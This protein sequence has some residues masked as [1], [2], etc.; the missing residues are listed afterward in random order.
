MKQRTTI[1][2]DTNDNATSAAFRKLDF[3]EEEADNS[4]VSIQL[5]SEGSG[6]TV[7]SGKWSAEEVSIQ[8]VLNRNY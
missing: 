6:A 8:T 4:K 1:T 7:N 2:L 3:D 5:Q